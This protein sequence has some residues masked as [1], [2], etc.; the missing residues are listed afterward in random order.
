MEEFTEVAEVGDEE[1]VE[2]GAA[3]DG[4][5]EARVP[6]R[7]PGMGEGGEVTDWGERLGGGG[8]DVFTSPPPRPTPTHPLTHPRSGVPRTGGVPGNQKTGGQKKK[9]YCI[10]NKKIQRGRGVH[11][12]GRRGG[13]SEDPLTPNPNRGLPTLK[14]SDGG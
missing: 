8:A 4:G 2:G 5:Q 6:D 10:F 13:V 3:E 14:R 11:L 1:V 12:Q 9:M 7:R